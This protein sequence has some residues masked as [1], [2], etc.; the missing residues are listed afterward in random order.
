[1]F[2]PAQH[3][4]LSLIEVDVSHVGEAADAI[5]RM[6]DGSLA[7][8]IVRGVLEASEV[9]RFVACLEQHGSELPTFKPPIF[10]GRVLGKPLVAA[11]EGMAD[12]L[13]QAELFRAGCTRIHPAYP[14]LERRLHDVISALSGEHPT[15]VPRGTRRSRVPCRDDPR[16]HRGR[17][18]AL[19]L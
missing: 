1:M 11:A 17:F 3:E 15:S 12:Y 5:A 16:A 19:A 7:G 2:D 13:E 6:H 18:P 10:K 8:V 9:A 4:G 14:D